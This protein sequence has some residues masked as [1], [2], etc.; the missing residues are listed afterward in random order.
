V[1]AVLAALVWLES[2]GPILVRERRRGLDNKAFD[3]LRFRTIR[4]DDLTPA[5]GAETRIGRVMRRFRLNEL[6]QL[7]QALAGQMSV[8][9]PRPFP[10]VPASNDAGDVERAANRLQVKPGVTGLSQMP[11]RTGTHTDDD[12]DLDYIK[13]WSPALDLRIVWRT[14]VACFKG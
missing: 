1:M 9:G 11:S 5:T 2:T 12:R 4:V 8:V 7:F 14:I 10:L 6:P 13:T 3:V